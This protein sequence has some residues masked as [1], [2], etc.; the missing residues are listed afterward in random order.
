MVIQ[1]KIPLLGS[2]A[3]ANYDYTDLASG[4]GFQTFY[5][6]ASL[7]DPSGG[8][9]DYHLITET[10][11][12]AKANENWANGESDNFD[13]STFNLPKTVKGTAF[14]SGSIEGEAG[15]TPSTITFTL[16][17]VSGSTETTIGS[18]TYSDA[19]TASAYF[20]RPITCTQTT[21]NSG[22]FLRLTV[23]VAASGGSIYIGT[24]PTDQDGSDIIPSSSD[25]TTIT[26]IEVPFIIYT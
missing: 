12:S 6:T 15:S 22:D 26:R 19:D 5:L 8:T 7:D 11:N 2:P 10:L 14:I 20:F 3:T 23:S 9:F 18:A 4:L 16:K 13:S 17:K 21:I 25:A 1:Q 24:S